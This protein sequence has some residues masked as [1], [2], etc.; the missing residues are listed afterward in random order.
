VISPS[1]AQ[2]GETEREQ[3]EADREGSGMFTSPPMNNQVES[4]G[5]VERAP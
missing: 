5:F 2:S 1:L 3:N 4:L